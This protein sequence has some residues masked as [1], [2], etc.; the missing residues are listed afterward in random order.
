MTA[1]TA[2]AGSGALWKSAHLW[3]PGMTRVAPTSSVKS[4]SAKRMLTMACGAARPASLMNGQMATSRCSTWAPCPG[5][6]IIA[7]PVFSQ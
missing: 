5:P 4:F 3:L 1:E 6:T 7:W 2:S